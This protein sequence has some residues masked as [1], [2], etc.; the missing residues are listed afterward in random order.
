MNNT[1]DHKKILLVEDDP[2]H[3]ML[4]QMNLRDAGLNNP[5][6]HVSDGQAALDYV[7]QLVETDRSSLLILLD[8]NLP[9]VD[10]YA[11]L[12]QLKSN[13]QT[14]NIPVIVLTSTDDA[15]EI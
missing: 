10:G 9:V 1:S 11:V 4:V 8:L 12:E 15:R 13:Q 5:I 2:G 3:A 6:D 14:R 7:Y